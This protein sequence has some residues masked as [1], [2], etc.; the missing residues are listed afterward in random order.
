[1][2]YIK[3]PIKETFGSLYWRIAAAFMVMLAVVGLAYIYITARLS[4][5]YFE[6]INQTLNR[7]TAY[8][9]SIHSSPFEN[10]KASDKAVA[11][12]FH[13]IMLINPSLEVYLLDTNGKILSYYA[14]Q[15]KIRLQKINLSPI[16]EFLSSS[17]SK[18][19]KGDDPR[20]PGVQKVFSAAQA[21]FGN[22]LNGYI[23]IVLAGEQYDN[24]ISYLRSNY[25]FELGSKAMLATLFFTV[26]IGLVV[27]RFITRNLRNIINVM[28]KFR[29]GDLSARISVQSSGDIKELSSIFNEM[30]DILT[31][32][33][34]KLKEVEVLRRELIAN[35]SH[36]LRTPIS[37]IHGYTETLQMKEGALSTEDRLRYLNIVHTSTE[38]LEK[39]VNEL[40]E[41][42][43]LEA[44]QV[45]PT[46][47]F[48]FVSELVS[49][50]SNKFYLKAKQ[51]GIV[52]QTDLCKEMH[53]VYADLSLI[54]RVIQNLIDNALKFTPQGGAVIVQTK[55]AGNGIETIVRDTGIGITESE[56]DFVFERYY[57]GH[58]S[59]KHQNNTGLG[60]AIAKK[61]LDLHDTSLVLQSQLNKGSSFT[62]ALPFVQ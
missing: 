47:E 30:A 2:Q 18:V 39:L 40:F 44:N 23:Y 17:N 8:D 52:L 19:I 46:R 62:F 20:H 29:Q 6:K 1:M 16:R 26:V 10:G 45:R 41:L 42:S 50:I 57:K 24:V 7:N 28:Q 48:F 51:K 58:N 32:N 43:K 34:E 54:E 38:K 33:I 56:Q 36:D 12:M 59:N 5:L 14:P 60:L 27:I 9:I 31:Q 61:I 3:I 37:I 53:P 13:N 55:K 22:S 4:G 49:D 21:R 11:E 15:K 25:M 35:I